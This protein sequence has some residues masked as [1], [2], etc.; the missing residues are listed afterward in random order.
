MGFLIKKKKKERGITMAV[1]KG[2][3]IAIYKEAALQAAK[4]LLY[5]LVEIERI[6][7]ASSNNE[8]TRIMRTCREK[9]L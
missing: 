7:K 6:K 3:E 1:T 2:T 4:E 8:I 9:Y 5:P